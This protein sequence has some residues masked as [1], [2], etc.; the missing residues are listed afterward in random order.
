MVF[1]LQKTLPRDGHHELPTGKL[2]WTNQFSAMFVI[3]IVE[4]CISMFQ[5]QQTYF[6]SIPLNICLTLKV[7]ITQGLPKKVTKHF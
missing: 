5:V 4:L 1:V 3:K 2:I 6:Q 7:S